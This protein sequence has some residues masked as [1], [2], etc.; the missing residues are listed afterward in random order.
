MSVGGYVLVTATVSLAQSKHFSL[1]PEQAQA[2]AVQFLADLV[3]I[4]TQDPPGDE[5]AFRGL[6]LPRTRQA[7]KQFSIT[8]LHQVLGLVELTTRTSG[9]AAFRGRNRETF[10]ESR[11]REMR[12]SGSMSENR[13]QSHA[14]PD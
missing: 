12:L 2:E 8:T 1:N 14:K 4:D 3:R 10:S 6:C 13:K 11:M 9:Q 7:S 5:S